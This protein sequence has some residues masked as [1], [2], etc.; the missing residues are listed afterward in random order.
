M[1]VNEKIRKKTLVQD[2][3]WQKMK[4]WWDKDT[5]QNISARCLTLLI[6][7][8]GWALCG[9]PQP[10]HES[11]MPLLSRSPLNVKPIKTLSS[12]RK[13]LQKMV[14]FIPF[15]YSRA[16]NNN[17][18]SNG[19]FYCCNDSFTDARFTSMLAK[20]IWEKYKLFLC[21]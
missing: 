12:V 17:M 18:I 8:V 7:A 14:C 5:D 11:M 2:V 9:R 13:H 21:C 16:F 4:S 15:I 10:E 3:F 6:F 20:Y 19:K 1:G